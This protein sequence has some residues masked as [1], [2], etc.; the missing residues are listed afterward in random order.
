MNLAPAEC[1]SG[2]QLRYLKIYMAGLPFV[3]VVL[4]KLAEPTQMGSYKET[5]GLRSVSVVAAPILDTTMWG[6]NTKVQLPK[7][8]KQ[9]SL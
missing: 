1:I 4:G 9:G 5:N 2:N 7:P 6:A 8:E 3:V